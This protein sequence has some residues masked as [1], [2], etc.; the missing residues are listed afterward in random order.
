MSDLF[1]DLNKIFK[2]DLIPIIIKY[3]KDPNNKLTEKFND[4]VNDP[5]LTLTK[6]LEKF[7]QNKNNDNN[8]RNYSDI[9]NVTDIEIVVDDEYDDLIK[10]LILIEE[11][12]V[13]IEKLLK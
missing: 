8:K 11:N 4:L 1:D 10:R 12:M 5:Q 9:K 13:N 3:L 6:F 2:K 7:S